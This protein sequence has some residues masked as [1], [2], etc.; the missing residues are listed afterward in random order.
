MYLH[1]K[2]YPL[3]PLYHPPPPLLSPFF[4]PLFLWNRML[5]LPPTYS[6]LRPLIFLYTMEM[7]FLLLMPDNAI[8]CYICDW[9]HGP[10]PVYS[11]VCGL[12]PGSSGGVWFVDIVVLMGFPTP[13]VPSVLSLTPPLV[14]LCLVQWFAASILICISKALAKPLRRHPCQVPVNKHFL[15]SA[16]VMTGFGGCIW[17]ESPDR[18]VS[19]WP[20]LQSLLHSLSLHFLLWVFCS[21]L[22]EEL[23]HPQFGL[24]SSWA[25]STPLKLCIIL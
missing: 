18:A 3:F 22:K 25:S 6:H 13:S 15:A 17:D 8:L 20:L 1:F 7:S 12:V 14:S 5:P 9:S 19:G 10:I 24:P 16:I 21:P 4:S 2:C 11:L 23:K